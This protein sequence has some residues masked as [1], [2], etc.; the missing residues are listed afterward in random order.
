[1]HHLATAPGSQKNSLKSHYLYVK[2]RYQ[3]KKRMLLVTSLLVLL[4][5]SGGAYLM[6]KSKRDRNKQLALQ[7]QQLQSSVVSSAHDTDKHE[8]VINT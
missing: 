7:A 5:F 8:P 1:Q 2:E 6:L 3:E 4:L